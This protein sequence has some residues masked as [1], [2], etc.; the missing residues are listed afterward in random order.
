[1][2]RTTILLP[3][4]LR[5]EAT[6]A[7]RQQGISLSE[8]IRK[9]LSEFVGETEPSKREKDALFNPRHLMSKHAPQD[10]AANHD[11]YLHEE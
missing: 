11:D 7:A 8:L 1:M 9:Q 4:K 5:R 2:H 6:K 10:L 3:E